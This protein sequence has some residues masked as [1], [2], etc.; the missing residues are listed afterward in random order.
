VALVSQG[1][2]AVTNL[3][4]SPSGAAVSGGPAFPDFGAFV[5]R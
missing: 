1:A 5:A 4:I 3:F 2:G